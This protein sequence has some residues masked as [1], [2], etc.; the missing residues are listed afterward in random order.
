[1]FTFLTLADVQ[2]T[3]IP[4]PIEHPLPKE[5]ALIRLRELREWFFLKATQGASK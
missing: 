5:L 3:Q 1:M 4:L 2:M